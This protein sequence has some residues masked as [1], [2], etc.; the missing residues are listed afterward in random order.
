MKWFFIFGFLLLSNPAWAKLDP[1]MFGA[2]GSELL[3]E[4]KESGVIDQFEK[5]LEKMLHE[6]KPTE[7][8][9]TEAET[10]PEETTDEMVE[11]INS[12]VEEKQIKLDQRVLEHLATLKPAKPE[13]YPKH[14]VHL[15]QVLDTI[16]QLGQM[17]SS[18]ID[19]KT[20]EVIK[21]VQSLAVMKTSLNKLLKKEPEVE[22]PKKGWIQKE[23]EALRVPEIAKKNANLGSHPSNF[24]LSADTEGLV[25][26]VSEFIRNVRAKPEF[27]LEVMLPIFSEYGL[28]GPDV[29]EMVKLYG[30]GL[31]KSESFGVFLEAMADSFEAFAK[32]E[33]GL[34]LV[35]MIPQLMEA[36]NKETVMSLFEAEVERGWKD[37]SDRMSSSD[38]AE[39]TLNTVASGLVSG[40]NLVQVLMKDD[41]KMA[42]AN[43]FLIS[44]VTFCSFHLNI[45]LKDFFV[46]FTSNQAQKIDC[47]SL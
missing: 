9:K 39:R 10:T 16:Y 41:M 18:E 17:D 43:T 38:V 30:K 15:G 47:L 7:E 11:F 27:I 12:Y 6:Q 23:G 1:D 21:R 37:F 45:Y 32:S 46:G 26:M 13:D 33:G 28:I 3:Q 2:Q 24:A 34:R 20:L 25:P 4:L 44:Q 8:G 42:F 31:V 35:E 40:V 22:A 29:V 5:E 19:Q 14:F 36:D